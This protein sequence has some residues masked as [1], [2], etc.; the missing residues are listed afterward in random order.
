MLAHLL[1]QFG[2]IT[3][4][5]YIFL[6]ILLTNRCSVVVMLSEG[7]S[8]ELNL[9][10]VKCCIKNMVAAIIPAESYIVLDA[11]VLITLA[12]MISLAL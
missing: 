11:V 10:E 7:R 3:F 9:V 12:I 2:G 4:I 1:Q 6:N 5:S 8:D